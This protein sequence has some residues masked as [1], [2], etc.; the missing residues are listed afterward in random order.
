MN[1]WWKT[2]FDDDYIR[3]WGQLF[4]EENNTKQALELWAMLDLSPVCRTTRL[5][6]DRPRLSVVATTRVFRM[7][8]AACPLIVTDVTR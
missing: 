5:E 7:L 2:F 4:S 6:T 3:L 1:E 8:V